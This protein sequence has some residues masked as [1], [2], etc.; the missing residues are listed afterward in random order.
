L[1]TSRTAYVDQSLA[2]LYGVA[3]PPAGAEVDERGFAQLELPKQRAGLLT[4]AGWLT[5][6]SR[7]DGPS[8]VARGLWVN[9][10]LCR[11]LPPP[12]NQIP[13]QTTTPNS[14]NPTQRQLSEFR[15]QTA[16]CKECHAEL[17]AYGLA[18]EEFDGIGRYRSADPQGRPIDTTVTLPAAAGG[19][20]VTGGAELSTAVAGQTFTKCLTERILQYAE[21]TRFQAGA[22]SCEAQAMA[23]AGKLPSDV[24]FAELVKHVALSRPFAHRQR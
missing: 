19:V 15:Q 11:E 18:L 20:Q 24:S 12:P 4:R 1:L 13:T 21:S 7:P 14:P 8:V 5:A 16:P 9:A 10:L 23:D 6:G 22:A 3:F 17:D 2:A